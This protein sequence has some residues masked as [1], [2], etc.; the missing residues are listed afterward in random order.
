MDEK[1]TLL[2][3]LAA[4]TAANCIP[5]FE[6]YYDKAQSSGL[7]PEEIAEAVEIAYQIK[8]NVNMLLKS[9]VRKI[10]GPLGEACPVAGDKSA[11]TCP[12]PSDKD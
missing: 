3:S 6:H 10:M 5:C 7:A 8:S 11:P 12:L 1:T 4:S 2:I 9:R